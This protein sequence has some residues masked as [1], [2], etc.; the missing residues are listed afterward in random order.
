VVAILQTSLDRDELRPAALA[1]LPPARTGRRYL[2]FIRAGNESLHG[3]MILENPDRNWDCCVSWYVPAAAEKLAEYYRGGTSGG[4]SNKLEGF[5]EFWERRPQPWPYRYVAILDDDVYLR[6]GELSRFFSLCDEYQ[7]YLAQPALQWFTH[8]TLNA[9]ARNPICALRRV[10]FVEVMAPCFSTA[11]IETLLHTFR[12]TKSTWGVDWAWA[13]LLEGREPLHV[14]D[15]VSM[16]HTRTGNGRPTPFYRK[17]RAA[18]IDP[19]EELR[20]VQRMFPAFAG[21]KTLPQGHVFRPEIPR[22]L[23]PGLMILF[24]RLKFIVRARKKFLRAWRSWRAR[25]E[26]LV[27]STESV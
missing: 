11:A 22:R 5:A 17:L 7:L 24:E 26:D 6:P 2:A 20:R 21:S 3:R 13:C 8:N 15:A 1:R 25:V 12:W 27:N 19:G 4:F 16:A 9:L 23:A 14:V 10:S 18:G